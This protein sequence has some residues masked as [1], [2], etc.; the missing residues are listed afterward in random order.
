MEF[1]VV[2]PLV[3]VAL[4]LLM[5]VFASKLPKWLA[6]IVSVPQVFILLILLFFS[7]GGI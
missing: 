5:F 6:I 1:Y 2:I 4:N 3:F 7:T